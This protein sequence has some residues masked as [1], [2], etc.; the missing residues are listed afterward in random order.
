[1]ARE[2][3]AVGIS[4]PCL[5]RAWGTL[6]SGLQGLLRSS[7]QVKLAD[8]LNRD[9]SEARNK[10]AACKNAFVLLGQHRYEMAAAF[11]LLGA[12]HSDHS[13]DALCRYF[14]EQKATRQKRRSQL[15]Q[16]ALLAAEYAAQHTAI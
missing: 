14:Q 16:S 6:D 8:F 11:F 9:F 10:E 15:W 7:Q 3:R 12:M 5:V 2:S 4:R 13:S 1:M